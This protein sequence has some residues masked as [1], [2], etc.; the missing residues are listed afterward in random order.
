MTLCKI[1]FS[2]MIPNK[3][4]NLKKQLMNDFLCNI[5]GDLL[6]WHIGIHS[7][8]FYSMQFEKQKYKALDLRLF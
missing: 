7:F 3:N 8:C 2:Q 4:D 5:M 1:F 6:S